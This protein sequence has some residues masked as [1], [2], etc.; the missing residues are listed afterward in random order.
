LRPT[1]AVIIPTSNSSK[2]LQACL[3]SI[4]AQTYSCV[5]IVVVDNFSADNTR[6]IAEEFSARVLD[7]GNP[8]FARNVGVRDSVLDYVFFVDSDEILDKNLVNEC[9]RLCEENKS[10]FVRI[11]IYFIGGSFIGNSSAFWKNKL[12]VVDREIRADS[13][14]D[15]VTRFLNRKHVIAA[16]LFDERL[17]IGEDVKFKQT[18]VSIGLNSIRSKSCIYHLEPAGLRDFVRKNFGYAK[19]MFSDRSPREEHLTEEILQMAMIAFWKSKITFCRQP[20]LLVGC[21]FLLLVKGFLLL[22]AR[23]S[24]L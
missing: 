2:T 20:L 1:V 17:T 12:S 21:S 16:G 10:S 4:R 24:T 15:T 18:L 22:V 6:R 5:E 13:A 11:P 9:V 14:S 19:F 3:R 7:G 8:A 23:I